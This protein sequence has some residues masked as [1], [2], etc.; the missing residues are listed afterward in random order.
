MNEKD[1]MDRLDE[2][3]RMDFQFELFEYYIEHTIQYIIDQD[4]LENSAS[5]IVIDRSPI[6]HLAYTINASPSMS[7]SQYRYLLSRIDRF[8]RHLF[9]LKYQVYVYAFPY[10][11]PWIQDSDS[12][13]GFRFDP[14]GKNYLISVLIRYEISQWIQRNKNYDVFRYAPLYVDERESTESKTY[15]TPKERATFIMNSFMSR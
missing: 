13:D 15:Y 12:S 14:F 10:P 1:F 9:N 2:S 6:D 3:D 4:R 5:V 11:T 7:H 8:F